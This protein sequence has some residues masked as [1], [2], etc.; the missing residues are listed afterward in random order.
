MRARASFLQS[1][2]GAG[3]RL[4]KRDGGYQA[5]RIHGTRM[6]PVCSG[7]GEVLYHTTATTSPPTD[8]TTTTT[9]TADAAATLGPAA[10]HVYVVTGANRGL[11]RGIAQELSQRASAAEPRHIILVGRNTQAL[12]SA[13]EACTG[14]HSH[15]YILGSVDLTETPGA[16]ELIVDKLRSVVAGLEHGRTVSLTLVHCAGT[17]SDLSKT[18]AQYTEAEV[19]AYTQLNFVAYG[20]LTSAFLRLVDALQ[21]SGRVAMVN[22][23]SLMAVQAFPNWGL[24]SAIKA[25]RDMLMRCAASEYAAWG[26]RFKTLNYA[27]GPLDNDMQAAVRATMGDREQREQFS[28]MHRKRRLVK[29][30]D[31]A[32]AMCSLLDAWAFES[33][34]HID[35]FDTVPPT[36]PAI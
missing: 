9:A 30:A 6:H 7:N 24:Y 17:I 29:V 19:Q 13:A 26:A 18:V 32:R 28:E 35:Y 36:Q 16:A 34:Q 10:A 8:M 1:P 31:S 33:G 25:A 2:S 15:T 12:G 27:P 14:T 20:A 4:E 23:S 11:G 5:L 22:I 21:V 3:G